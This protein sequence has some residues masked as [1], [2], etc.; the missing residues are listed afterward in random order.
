MCVHIQS[1]A[2]GTYEVCLFLLMY[3]I[4]AYAKKRYGFSSEEI[5]TAWQLLKVSEDSAVSVSCS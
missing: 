5:D 3:R 4:S 2:C 1:S